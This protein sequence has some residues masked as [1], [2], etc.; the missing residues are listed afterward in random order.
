M[1]NINNNCNI[2]L[3]NDILSPKIKYNKP[4][5]VIYISNL[6][7]SD[8]INVKLAKKLSK[9][10]KHNSILFSSKLLPITI[11][12]KLINIKLHQTWN[13][14][15]VIR[16]CILLI[17]L[18]RKQKNINVLIKIIKLRKIKLFI[19]FFRVNLLF[20]LL[21]GVDF[22]FFTLPVKIVHGCEGRSG[23]YGSK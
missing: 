3:I 19:Y 14:N 8:N 1:N 18:V 12:H 15:I 16:I 20:F 13:A 21:R 6:C 23:I 5:S 22:D 4:K 7:F 11:S 9:E 17:K 2:E 10:L